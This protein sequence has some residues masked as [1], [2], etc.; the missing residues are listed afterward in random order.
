MTYMHTIK[1]K[2]LDGKWAAKLFWLETQDN[3]ENKAMG[4]FRGNTDGVI[5]T[6]YLESTLF[7]AVELVYTKAF[8]FG[9]QESP[10]KIGLYY[11]E[12]ESENMDVPTEQDLEEIK[13]EAQKRGWDH[14]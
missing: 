1:V 11:E 2:K 4:K 8:Q 7:H 14:D 5:S 9:I 6:T 13:A 10:H 3:E 12:D